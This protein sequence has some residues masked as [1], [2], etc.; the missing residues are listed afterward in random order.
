MRGREGSPGRR[1]P[2]VQVRVS[3]FPKQ[4][5]V[6]FWIYS[7]PTPL[8][9]VLVVAVVTLLAIAGLYATRGIVARIM[10]PPPGHNEGVDSY[11]HTVSVLYGLILGLTAVAVWEHYV[12]VEDKVSQ[13][14]SSLGA[15]YRDVSSYPEPQRS[16]LQDQVRGYT[17]YVID[18]AWPLQRQG[19][20][21]TEG[22]TRLDEV[23]KTLY[24]FE[25]KTEEQKIADATTIEEF[26]R[27]VE[28]RR[29]RLHDVNGGLPSPLWAVIL[30]GALISIIMGYFFALQRFAVHV[31]MTTFQAMM[32]SLILFMIIVVDHPLRG[33]ISVSPN[34][35]ELI[36]RQ[37]MAQ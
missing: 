19:V 24:S 33:G 1:A 22:V 32:I 25:P 6:F 5:T 35:F 3:G 37:L 18:K 15:L 10:G 4:T 17:R 12:T 2:L 14:A 16:E 29:S 20:V 13:E 31:T 28:L 8:L 36:Y 9:G 7:I 21:P 34:A 30:L 23:E 11:I 26:N 27:Y